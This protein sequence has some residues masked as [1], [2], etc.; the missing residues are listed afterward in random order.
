MLSVASNRRAAH[1]F[2]P[3]MAAQ[4]RWGKYPIDEQHWAK[5]QSAQL[6]WRLVVLTSSQQSNLRFFSMGLAANGSI[7]RGRRGNRKQVARRRAKRA[8]RMEQLED[9]RLMHG[10]PVA[11]AEDPNHDVLAAAADVSPTAVLPDLIPWVDEAKGFLYGWT[12]RGNELRLT[13]AMANIGSGALEIRGGEIIGENIQQV[14]QR[15]YEP[16]GSFNDRLAG[17]FTY[18][19]EH[20]HIH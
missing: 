18:H 14:Y 5:N 19:P 13:T 11:H 16:D 12:L 10:D 3:A 15:V 2:Q 9:R 1:S 4:S 8:L 17:T 20:K 7:A 6:A